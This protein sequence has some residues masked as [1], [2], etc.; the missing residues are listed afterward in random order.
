MIRSCTPEDIP[1]LID[2][3]RQSVRRGASADYSRAQC[4][5][6]APDHIDRDAWIARCANRP[7][8]VAENAGTVTGFIDLESNG[9]IDMLFV[10]PDFHRQGIASTLLTHVESEA[11]TE[12][13]ERLF[14]EV[15]LT[16]RPVF[17]KA[18]FVIVEQQVVA[19]N[20]ERFKNFRMQKLL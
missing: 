18:G 6:W 13:I 4:R 7:T 8:W 10:H 3:F 11:L 14:A 20:G 1:V 5:A 15:S 19:R 12:N 17:E 16:A 9:H 2:L